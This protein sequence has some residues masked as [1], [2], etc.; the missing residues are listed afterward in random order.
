MVTTI[1]SNPLL[2]NLGNPRIILQG[3]RAMVTTIAFN[4]LLIN[5]RFH[6]AG[7]PKMQSQKHNFTILQLQ[8]FLVNYKFYEMLIPFGFYI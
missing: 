3:V 5:G 6:A 2:I 8:N 4:P 1:V 7:T